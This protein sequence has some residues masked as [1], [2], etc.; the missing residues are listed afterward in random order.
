MAGKHTKKKTPAH[1]YGLKFLDLD[2][3]TV[4]QMASIIMDLQ[5]QE[6]KRQM[7]R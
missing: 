1:E 6:M 3:D 4:D 2:T 5:R 7:G